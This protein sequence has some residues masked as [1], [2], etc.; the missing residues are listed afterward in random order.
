MAAQP[1][2]AVDAPQPSPNLE[3]V[4][5]LLTETMRSSIPPPT[6]TSQTATASAASQQEPEFSF[7]FPAGTTELEREEMSE[8]LRLLLLDLLHLENDT[9][10]HI[11]QDHGALWLRLKQLEQEVHD[12]AALGKILSPILIR[13]IAHQAQRA[14]EQLA[15]ALSRVADRM[16]QLQVQQDPAAMSR[17]LAVT[18]PG[19]ISQQLGDQ[20]DEVVQAIA[21]AMGQ[22]ITEQIR[23]NPDSMVDALYP[24]IGSTISK[25][26]GEIANQINRRIEDTFS[27]KRFVERLWLRWQGISEVDQVLRDA[28]PFRV[29]A[30]FLIHK[31][32]GLV[33][34]EVQQSDGQLLEGDL[35][36]GMLTAIRSFASECTTDESHHSELTKI[37]YDNFQ[38]VME[39]AGSCYIAA[40]IQGDPPTDFLQQL[41]QV[42]SAMILNHGYGTRL[43]AYNGDPA[44]VP[45]GIRDLLTTLVYAPGNTAP[46]PP[47][48]LLPPGFV[49]RL[50]GLLAVCALLL[51]GAIAWQMW[52]HFLERRVQ[53]AIRETPALAVYRLNAD[54]HWR[55]VVLTG[56][57]PSPTLKSQAAMLIKEIIPNYYVLKDQVATPTV[58][59][60]PE[61]IE[62]QAQRATADLSERLQA[63]IVTTYN[64]QTQA[65]TA[66][67]PVVEE[68]QRLALIA[69]LQDI[70]G[71]ET[72][73]IET[74][75]AIQPWGERVYFDRNEEVVPAVERDHLEDL[76]IYLQAHPDLKL[77]VI[78][79]TDQS[80]DEPYNEGLA[81][82]RADAVKRFLVQE[83][84]I[85]AQRL[86]TRGDTGFPPGV[87]IGHA[88]YE[89]R[90]VRFELANIESEEPTPR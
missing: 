28:V 40:V 88:M 26:M 70:T 77:R 49:R 38:I 24:V 39:V 66:Q 14:P 21:P 72:V 4:F 6:V 12:A 73:V 45:D 64:A 2:D 58:P 55:R 1:H 87:G 37:D 78:G 44:T 11:D 42:L 80:G 34:A 83:H 27:P 68:T 17:A 60:P 16:I 35:L 53:Q 85:D 33:M 51:G 36:A 43:G 31:A 90:C 29:Q 25:Y 46:P 76:A 67:L 79:H 69:A 81:Q 32:S 10:I 86:S 52:E 75:R 59:P 71:V 19:A 9:D 84:N 30:A 82:R 63:E 47:V 54:V 18:I 7:D 57:V 15:Q 22:A 62:D 89:S 8:R 20:P 41:R 50:L 23:L 3:E 61:V 5:E 48:R 56:A 74:V 65:L 13:L